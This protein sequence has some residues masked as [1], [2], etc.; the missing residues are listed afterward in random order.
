[1]SGLVGNPEDRFSCVAAHFELDS[2]FHGHEPSQ[3]K[4]YLLGF[5]NEMLGLARV[6]ESLIVSFY[7]KNM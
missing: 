2:L 5:Q 7:R 6:F 3:E 1:M 4:T